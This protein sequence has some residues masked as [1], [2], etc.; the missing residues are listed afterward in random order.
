MGQYY[1][2]DSNN[3]YDNIVNKNFE[4]HAKSVNIDKIS[5]NIKISDSKSHKS[6]DL[7]NLRKECPNNPI[8]SYLNIN[9]LGNK[10]DQL[11]DICK[12][13]S[14]DILCIDE[15]KIDSSFPDSQFYIEC[16]QFPPFRRDRDING[17]GKIV[18][19]KNGII[20]KRISNLKEFPLKSFV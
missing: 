20:A 7:I 4:N 12:K 2:G 13:A 11:R 5:N 9:S 3:N 10:I 6:H 14:V 19:I 17:G 16:Y 1:R 18:C 15:T 8:I